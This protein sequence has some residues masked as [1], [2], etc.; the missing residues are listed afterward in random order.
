MALDFLFSI[1]PA[2][3]LNFI[4]RYCLVETRSVYLT[5]I[6]SIRCEQYVGVSEPSDMKLISQIKINFP[7][8]HP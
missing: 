8:N 4:L 7:I 2:Q 1:F 6:L 5:F 3:N